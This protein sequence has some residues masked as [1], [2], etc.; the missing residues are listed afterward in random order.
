MAK[1]RRECSHRYCQELRPVLLIEQTTITCKLPDDLAAQLNAASREQGRP[2]S[3]I[4]REALEQR[5]QGS[6]KPVVYAFD[7]VKQL[8][9]SIEEGP[10]DLATNPEHLNGFGQ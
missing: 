9:G 8:C 6:R 3:A 2:K 1:T 4:L 5:L 7:L 10:A